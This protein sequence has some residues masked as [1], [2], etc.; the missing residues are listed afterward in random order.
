MPE[1]QLQQYLRQLLAAEVFSLGWP[2][3]QPPESLAIR[4]VYALYEGETLMYVGMSGR[5]QQL[6]TGRLRQ[7]KEWSRRSSELAKRVDD[8]QRIRT[9][10]VRAIEIEDDRERSQF[11]HY[12]IALL[13]PPFNK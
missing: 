8:P 12:A 13:W 7:H 1:E 10:G 2:H 5:G 6:I 4:G 9:W 3:R 11:E